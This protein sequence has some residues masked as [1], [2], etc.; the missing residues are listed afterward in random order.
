MTTSI[1]PFVCKYC[2]HGYS[3][4]STL[5][6]HVCEQKRRALAKTD[7]HVIIGYDAYR[8]F[9]KATQNITHDKTY[10][11]F[12]KSPYYNAFIKFGSFVSNVNP[13]Y[14]DNFINYVIKSGVKLDHW[15]RDEMYD[16][17][18]VNLIKHETV[19]TALT[20][21][22]LHMEEW[23]KNNNIDWNQYF[24]HVSLSRATYDIKDGK[25]SPW[26]ILNAPTGKTLLKKF[27]DEQLTAISIVIDPPYWISKFKKSP[28]D[29]E[30]IK[31]IIKE[32]NL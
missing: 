17:Y 1:K 19:E 13:L 28:S 24:S 4:E 8:K 16:K 5:Q 29:M 23:A 12:C 30:L 31:Q 27:N 2:N 32:A 22:I 6:T 26:L 21:S 10:E 15:C 7:K 20:R 25:I 3:R 18:V 14:P 11:D 9:Y